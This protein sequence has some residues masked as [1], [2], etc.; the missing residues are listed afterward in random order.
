MWGLRYSENMWFKNYHSSRTFYKVTPGYCGL[1]ADDGVPDGGP[2]DG[3]GGEALLSSSGRQKPQTGKFLHQ[4][5]PNKA[6]RGCWGF[7]SETREYNHIGDGS[8]QTHLYFL[9]MMA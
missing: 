4:R 2:A 3:R 1:P 5:H 6:K 9:C 7:Q 8:F